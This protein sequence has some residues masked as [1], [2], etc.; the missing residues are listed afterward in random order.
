MVGSQPNDLTKNQHV[1][2]SASRSLLTL[3]AP[4]P[5]SSHSPAVC[6][7]LVCC[8]AR[9]LTTGASGL[10]QPL[11]LLHQCM[12]EITGMQTQTEP[13][14]PRPC[15]RGCNSCGAARVRGPPPRHSCATRR[16]T[17]PA[18]LC[19][20]HHKRNTAGNSVRQ[21]IAPR[22]VTTD[23]HPFAG[24]NQ[25]HSVAAPH[26]LLVSRQSI[27]TVCGQHTLMKSQQ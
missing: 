27:A 3:C 17:A 15:R 24:G 11:Q 20:S 16:Q 5:Q 7:S 10:W 12:H 22:A 9:T 13:Q 4:C 8:T 2:L 6:Y 21:P 23:E 1:P 14:I 26:A 18:A 25:Q 19:L